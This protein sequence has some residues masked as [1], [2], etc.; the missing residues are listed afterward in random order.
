MWQTASLVFLQP[1]L[2]VEESIRI[3]L[4]T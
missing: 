1:L 2:F 4:T 3:C